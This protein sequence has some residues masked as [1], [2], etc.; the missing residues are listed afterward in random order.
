M[1]FLEFL[2]YLLRAIPDIIWS[3]ILA[4]VLTLLGVF[5]SNS[6]NTARLELQLKHDTNEKEKERVISMRR[7][8]YLE[9]IEELVHTNSYLATLPNIDIKNENISDGLRGMHKALA[10]IQLVAQ[11]TTA[12][13]AAEATIKYGEIICRLAAKLM[14]VSEA[15]NARDLANT[16][17]EKSQAEV[18]RI[19]AAQT[20]HNESAAK[21]Q[22]AIEALQHN[23]KFFSDLSQQYADARQAAWTDYNQKSFV[24]SQAL[25]AELRDIA[26]L[27]NALLAAIREDLGLKGGFDELMRL[28]EE[29][30]KRSEVM[31][32]D[33]FT[34]LGMRP[35]F[36]QETEGLSTET[37]RVVN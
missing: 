17:Y 10:R 35:K 24:W 5:A 14:P 36:Q 16:Y 28:S 30:A 6:S 15:R 11:P 31:L 21:D 34:E 19:L 8:V 9:A 4:S 3:G 20:T 29:Q 7:A 13:L 32:S 25:M 12:R 37:R 1:E 2:E 18:E 23:L 22:F 33:L 27:N 26:P